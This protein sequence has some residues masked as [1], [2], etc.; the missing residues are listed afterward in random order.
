MQLHFALL[1]ARLA[2]ALKWPAHRAVQP[3][4]APPTPQR[5]VCKAHRLITKLKHKCPRRAVVVLVKPEARATRMGDVR[6][7]PPLTIEDIQ[8]ADKIEIAAGGFV[9]LPLL[10]LSPVE[11]LKHA[12]SITACD[13]RIELQRCAIAVAT[14]W[15]V[16]AGADYAA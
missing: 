1:A 9:A 7:N 8:R 4:P 13:I 2:A 10:Q 6:S 5:I 3:G 11:I 12:S 14:Q 16:D 15:H